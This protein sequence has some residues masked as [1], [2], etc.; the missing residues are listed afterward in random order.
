M[1]VETGISEGEYHRDALLS[2][3]A[4]EADSRMREHGSPTLKE[5]TDTTVSVSE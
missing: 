3:T 4:V 5:R 2:D 1:S